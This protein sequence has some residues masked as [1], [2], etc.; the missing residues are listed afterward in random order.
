MRNLSTEVILRG[1]EITIDEIVVYPA[2]PDV[3]IMSSYA[4]GYVLK[5]EDG[6]ELDWTLTKEEQDAIDNAID[7]AI[8]GAYE[9]DDDL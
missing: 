4:D 3:G 6:N 9:G 1:R 2:E 5:D 7:D 8:A